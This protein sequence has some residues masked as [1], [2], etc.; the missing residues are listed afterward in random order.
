MCAWYLLCYVQ[1]PKSFILA[2]LFKG[3]TKRTVQMPNLY[4]HQAML[5][6]ETLEKSDEPILYWKAI[7]H[8]PSLK[9][10]MMMLYGLYWYSYYQQEMGNMLMPLTWF[11]SLKIKLNQ[12]WI[13]DTT[14]A[15]Y[16]KQK[17]ALKQK[18]KG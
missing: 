7:K 6:R 5:Y 9:V 13:S 3:Q 11:T 14:S 2:S 1:F 18:N 12:N 4:I 15:K 10:L 8:P 16:R 17:P